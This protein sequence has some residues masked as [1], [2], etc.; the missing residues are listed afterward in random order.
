MVSFA[1]KLRIG[2]YNNSYTPL[3]AKDLFYDEQEEDRTHASKW[4]IAPVTP[5]ILAKESTESSPCPGLQGGNVLDALVVC[6]G[7][8]QYLLK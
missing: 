2:D 7:E 6:M 1:G 3:D 5:R 8:I 4:T